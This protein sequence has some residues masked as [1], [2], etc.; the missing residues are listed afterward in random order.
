MAS[1]PSLKHLVFELESGGEFRNELQ[2]ICGRRNIQL[3]EYH[4]RDI[5]GSSHSGSAL[6]M[7]N[8][9]GRYFERRSPFIESTILSDPCRSRKLL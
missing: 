9:R 1:V 7:A 3:Q 5:P 8:S 6:R 2:D 4:S